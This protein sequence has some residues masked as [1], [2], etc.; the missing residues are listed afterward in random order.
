M[1][2]I[3][4]ILWSNSKRYYYQNDVINSLPVELA[5]TSLVQIKNRYYLYF[6][7]I[8]DSAKTYFFLTRNYQ[9]IL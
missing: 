3:F 9:A 6:R 4:C 8:L 1:V 5:N 2:E 7:A